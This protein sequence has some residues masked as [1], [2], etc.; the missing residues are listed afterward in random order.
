MGEYF[1]DEKEKERIP[2][3]IKLIT[4]FNVLCSSYDGLVV[5][6][7][8]TTTQGYEAIL[9]IRGK[10]IGLGEGPEDVG[11]IGKL[12]RRIQD[13]RLYRMDLGILMW[14]TLENIEDLEKW[15][16]RYI[17]YLE[18]HLD[19][20]QLVIKSAFSIVSNLQKEIVNLNVEI[21]R[22]SDK[23]IVQTEYMP[24]PMAS[25]EVESESKKFRIALEEGLKEYEEAKSAENV[26]AIKI[27]RAK[28]FDV[29]N[30]DVMRWD[31][32]QK[33]INLIDK[34][35]EKSI[36]KQQIPISDSQTT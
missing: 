27:A 14:N 5:R 2:Q 10:L 16:G 13:S 12:R 19:A 33:E 20:L 34:R 8:E 28:I 30:Q 32:A 18:D 6:I 29:C 7:N 17:K 25:R 24:V 11:Q 4:D 22:L 15:S 1:K 9:P 3:E 31:I 36:K 35:I 23:I 26:K 21:R